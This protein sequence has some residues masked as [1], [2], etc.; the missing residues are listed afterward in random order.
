MK[1]IYTR[2]GDSGSTALHGGQRV[3]KTHPRIEANGA[4]DELNTAIGTVRAFLP[5]SHPQMLPLRRL[6]LTL[7]TVMSRVA[8]PPSRLP[9]NPNTLPPGL[10]ADIEAWIDS[11]ALEAGPSE[12][13]LLPGGTPAAAFMH[14]ARVA[15]RRAERRLW[16]LCEAEP[17]PQPA[18]E[19]EI[20]C[21]VNRL[22]DLFF[23]MAR[24]EAV[25]AGAADE[26]WKLFAYS[27][28]KQ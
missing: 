2:T 7:M 18:V 12:W 10:V 4:L 23:V 19:D 6:Q 21:F 15:A 1:R 28:K 24:A 26:R 11:L 17:G 25:A 16:Q 20:I 9:L 8:T 5:Q 13:F 3:S 22:S 14:E 27:R